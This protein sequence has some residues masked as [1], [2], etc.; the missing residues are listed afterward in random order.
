[1][2]GCVAGRE[3]TLREYIEGL[4]IDALKKERMLKKHDEMKEEQHKVNEWLENCHREI[5]RLNCTVVNLAKHLSFAE[6]MI[7]NLKGSR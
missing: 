1:M 6:E 2:D 3:A 5:D 4:D 7:D